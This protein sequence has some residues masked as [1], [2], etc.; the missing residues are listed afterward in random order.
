MFATF[1]DYYV[2]G[3]IVDK[4]ADAAVKC[5][6][7]HGQVMSS[8]PSEA[9]TR[10]A[11]K[12]S[13]IWSGAS[14]IAAGASFFNPAIG[15][16]VG[17]SLGIPFVKPMYSG[18]RKHVITCYD[19]LSSSKIKRSVAITLFATGCGIGCSYLLSPLAP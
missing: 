2:R 17:L 18:L 3:K 8:S 12:V 10:S 5:I 14:G 15:I 4:S 11:L 7:N 19:I 16:A 1:F 6:T 9:A 13:L